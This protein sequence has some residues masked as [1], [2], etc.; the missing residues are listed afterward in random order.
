MSVEL[1]IINEVYQKIFMNKNNKFVFF[2]IMSMFLLTI[3]FVGTATK[4]EAYTEIG[5]EKTK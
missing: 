2:G 4:A 1:A 5:A 3:A